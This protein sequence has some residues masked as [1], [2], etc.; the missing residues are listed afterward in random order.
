M[1]EYSSWEDYLANSRKKKSVLIPFPS[2]IVPSRFLLFSLPLPWALGPSRL[3]PRSVSFPSHPALHSPLS[4]VRSMFDG[5]LG[6]RFFRIFVRGSSHQA[7][8]MM[9]YLLCLGTRYAML[10]PWLP[11]WCKEQPGHNREVY[12]RPLLR[13]VP[14][15]LHHPRTAELLPYRWHHLPDAS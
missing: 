11:G 4:A 15:V 13:S 8:W 7:W 5:R 3:R 9:R 10:C 14:V 12:R 2:W 1:S 6:W